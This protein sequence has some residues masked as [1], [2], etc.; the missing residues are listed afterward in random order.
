MFIVLLLEQLKVDEPNLVAR[1]FDSGSD[2]F[3]AQRLEPKV[4]FRIQQT[5]RVDQ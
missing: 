4:D 3:Q 1:V 2:A 5:A